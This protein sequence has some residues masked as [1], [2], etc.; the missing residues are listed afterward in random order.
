MLFCQRCG[1]K[2]TGRA[3]DGRTRPV[4]DACGAVTYEDPK[5]AVAVVVIRDNTVLLGLRAG[6]TRNP[7]TWSFPAGFVERGEQVEDAAVR[8]AREETGLAVTLGPLLGVW[9]SSG[10]P[11]VLLAYG[12]H[13]EDGSEP[14]A[15]DDLNRV[16]WWPI[17]DLPPLAFPHDEAILAAWTRLIGTT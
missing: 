5:L 3:V 1:G 7:G 9:S 12:A 6:H 14:V 17:S 15:G 16:A 13:V 2:A 8:E 4:C 10:E 11:V